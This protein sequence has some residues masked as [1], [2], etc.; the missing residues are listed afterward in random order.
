MCHYTSFLATELSTGHL[1]EQ[2]GDSLH[3]P[4]QIDDG[5]VSEDVLA[6]TNMDSVLS[7][8]TSEADLSKLNDFQTVFAS[9]ETLHAPLKQFRKVD[10]T[11]S[12][13]LLT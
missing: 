6:S 4:G 7:V 13:L 5:E 9:L 2:P 12:Y 3:A 1:R 11:S 10:R 8:A